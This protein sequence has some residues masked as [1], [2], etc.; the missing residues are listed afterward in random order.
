MY[1]NPGWDGTPV[2]VFV[3]ESCEHSRRYVPWQVGSDPGR[4]PRRSAVMATPGFFLGT[5]AFDAIVGTDG[6]SDPARAA[7]SGAVR[8]GDGPRRLHVKGAP[9]VLRELREALAVAG[10]EATAARLPA[11]AGACTDAI[12]MIDLAL[13]RAVFAP[14]LER[15]EFEA[16][17]KSPAPEGPRK[18]PP[19]KDPGTMRRRG[20]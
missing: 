20:R 13:K 19:R 10:R 11:R 7:L 3:L 8:G 18:A 9:A 12:A 2:S 15:R 5:A 4:D 1:A 6:L 14:P 17:S 16:D